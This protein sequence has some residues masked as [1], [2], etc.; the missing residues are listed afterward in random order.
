LLKDL[1]E[2]FLLLC[3]HGPNFGYFPEPSKCFVVVAS[4]QLPVANDVL[5]DLGIRIVTGHRFLGGFIGDSGDRQNFVMQKVLNWS[6]HVRA[7]AAVASLQ[8]QGAY[9]ALTKSLQSEWLFTLQVIPHCGPLFADLEKSLSSCFLPALFGVEVS[10]TERQ[11]FSLPLQFGGLGIFNPVAMSDY[12]YDSSVRSTLLLRK[13]ILGSVTFELDAHIDTV[14]SA[15]HFDRQHKLNHYTVV[16]DQL[17]NMFDSLQQWAILRAKN[18]N[19]SLWLSVVPLET[20]HFDLSPQEFR[21]AL[22]L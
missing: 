17:I 2:W 11:L 5:G 13:S 14:Q 6:N 16:F 9:A 18:S 12:C 1:R 3:S 10:S 21:N 7:F 8:P 4:S 22:A 20:H 19:L 15:K